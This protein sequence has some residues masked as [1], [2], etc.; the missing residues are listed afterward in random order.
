VGTGRQGVRWARPV[1]ALRIG[2]PIN[3]G[4]L[5]PDVVHDLAYAVAGGGTSWRGVQEG[6]Q[7]ALRTEPKVKCPLAQLARHIVRVVTKCLEQYL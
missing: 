3:Q 1:P 5:H 4:C 7:L 6:T 2:G